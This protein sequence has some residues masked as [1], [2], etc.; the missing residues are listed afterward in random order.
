[1]E[2]LYDLIIIGSGPAG[3]SAAI[4]AQRA[5]LK[6]LVLEA[7]YVSGGQVVNTYEV[8][9]YPALPGISGMDLGSRMR[10]HADR[11]GSVFA[12][13]KAEE[14]EMEGAVK[15]VR[16]R[17]NTYRARTLILAMGAVHR[18]L[19]IPGEDTFAGMGV[20]YCATCDGAF[21][22]GRTVAV[23]GGGDVA[24]E[25]AIF[26][27]RG[28]E[29][30]FLI[31]RRDS[32][33]AAPVLQ[34]RLLS[35]PNVEV[36]WNTVVKE[37][38]GMEQ[39]EGIRLE[40]VLTGEHWRLQADGCFIAVGIQ[41]SNELAKGKLQLDAAGYIAAGED[42]ATSVPG[43]FAAGDV[44]TKRLRQIITAAADGANCVTSVQDYLIK[45]L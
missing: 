20:S 34:E 14:V 30:V 38:E 43:V 45:T 6:T 42:G 12:R 23:V 11:M 3:L 24:V 19:Q 26:L 31:H 25:D 1:M 37:I 27:A 16:T 10:E 32:L 13:E 4:Y 22:K 33:R 9:N 35:L 8:D 17:K 28:C 36:I 40:N 21:F 41:P 39:V 29:K 5:K 2:E 44:R 18:K 7:S 15:T